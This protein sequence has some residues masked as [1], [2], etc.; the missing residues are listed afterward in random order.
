MRLNHHLM[1]ARF[2]YSMLSQRN[3]TNKAH[4]YPHEVKATYVRVG[5]IAQVIGTERVEKT[6]LCK[7]ID[8]F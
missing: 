7:I 3:K 5:T 8:H 2:A 6:C 1:L 4:V